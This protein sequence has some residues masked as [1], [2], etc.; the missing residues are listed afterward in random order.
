MP[1]RRRISPLFTWR[2]AIADRDLPKTIE[3][4]TSR[5]SGSSVKHVAM[6]LSLYMSERGDSAFPAVA[7]LAHDAS[8]SERTVR[9]A[10]RV[11]EVHGFLETTRGGGRRAD[12]T[13]IP[14]VYRAVIPKESAE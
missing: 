2:S 9:N 7:T 14:N 13:G 10:L 11:L 3:V 5:I 8:L 1:K 12:R 4:G 6:T